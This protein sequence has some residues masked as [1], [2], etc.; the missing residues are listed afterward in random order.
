VVEDGPIN[1][2]AGELMAEQ[3]PT[4]EVLKNI[5]PPKYSGGRGRNLKYQIIEVG[6]CIFFETPKEAATFITSQRYQFGKLGIHSIRGMY[7]R[8]TA[9]G[10]TG[11]WRI[12]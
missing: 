5:P 10:Q 7:V 9:N 2:N 3:H 1:S 11:V 8:E 12:K 4:G 6:E